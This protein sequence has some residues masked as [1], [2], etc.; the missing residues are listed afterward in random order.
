[1][2][3]IYLFKWTGRRWQQKTKF[4]EIWF[5]DL[6][7]WTTHASKHSIALS[8]QLGRIYKIKNF[9]PLWTTSIY[10]ASFNPRLCYSILAWGIA[11]AANYKITLLQKKALRLR[12]LYQ[13]KAGDSPAHPFFCQIWRAEIWPCALY[14][15]NLFPKILFIQM[16]LRS[17]HPTILEIQKYERKPRRNNYRKHTNK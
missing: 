8:K 12:E 9:I 3:V 10:Y 6:E 16:L 11:S 13:R 14:Y 7:S 17:A 5:S 2:C 4:L 15:L 1:M